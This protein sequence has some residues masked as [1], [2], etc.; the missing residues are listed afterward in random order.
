M[1][2]T[3][4]VLVCLLALCTSCS[5]M[6]NSTIMVVSD[7]HYFSPAMY[8]GSSL[9]MQAI[10]QGDGKVV[11][12]SDVLLSAL[13][14]QAE[15]IHPDA[16]LLT[17]DLTFNG[18][19]QSHEELAAALDSLIRQG[20][21]VYVIPGNH[22]INCSSAR[23]FQSYSYTPAETVTPEE[24]K[25]IYSN[26][27]G[28]IPEEQI[29]ISYTAS[30]SP[31]LMI[32]MLDCAFYEPVAYS[33]G[34][35]DENR[36]AWFVEQLSNATQSNRLFLS[37]THHNII[38]HSSLWQENF[39]VLNAERLC[40]ALVE[41][42][43]SI[44]FSGHLHIQHIAEQNGL[45]DIASGAFSVYPHRYG[46]I[47]IDDHRSITYHAAPL[48]EN[49]LPAGFLEESEQWFRNTTHGK[50][51]SSLKDKDIPDADKDIMLQYAEDL[52]LAYFSGTL[53]LQDPMWKDRMGYQL[54]KQNASDLS[55][56]QYLDRLLSE[57]S[58]DALFL[59][60]P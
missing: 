15:R 8:E 48:D 4:L 36:Y 37:A 25:A 32:C 3:F 43:V 22:D 5:A 41:H 59:S 47:E 23:S 35:L 60:I 13:I 26:C 54:W 38:P 57:A 11:H 18:E 31:D 30:P 7:L 52:N 55:F 46:L 56:A 28:E 42:G 24:F 12:H 58:P 2:K 20:I 6:A 14:A 16:L 39:V 33:F 44:H 10:A 17:G 49:L 21:A 53:K 34:F 19:K 45:Y 9:F 50:T 27:L 29:G 1:K 40:S 51:G